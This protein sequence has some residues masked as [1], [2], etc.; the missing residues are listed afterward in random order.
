MA[1]VPPCGSMFT[2]PQPQ[3]ISGSSTSGSVA[4]RSSRAASEPKEKKVLWP[5]PKGAGTAASP[6]S[7]PTPRP[8]GTNQSLPCPGL[9]PSATASKV[10][11][12]QFRQGCFWKNCGSA[13]LIQQI[14]AK[15]R[16]IILREEPEW[17]DK[18]GPSAGKG[19]EHGGL[20]T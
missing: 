12:R 2:R 9:A 4:Q 18:N 13:R 15:G 16:L 5:R 1:L 19:R 8:T 7:P 20:L 17:E 6:T 3:S 10:I 14:G 11:Q